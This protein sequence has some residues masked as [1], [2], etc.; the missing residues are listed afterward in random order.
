MTN[1]IC[2]E[3]CLCAWENTLSVG[4]TGGAVCTVGISDKKGAQNEGESAPVGTLT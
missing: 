1:T 4:V 3:V 2:Y